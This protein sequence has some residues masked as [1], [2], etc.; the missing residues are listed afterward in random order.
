MLRILHFTSVIIC[1]IYSEYCTSVL[2]FYATSLLWVLLSSV[3]SIS[4]VYSQY[5]IHVLC[6]LYV[7]IGIHEMSLLITIHLFWIREIV[8]MRLKK[9]CTLIVHN[10]V[11]IFYGGYVILTVL[12]FTVFCLIFSRFLANPSLRL[13]VRSETKRALLLD[14]LL[15]LC[16]ITL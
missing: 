8:I 3:T 13:T 7:C 6:I 5:C 9:L 16:V 15:V 10:T 1:Y 14:I 11:F 12:E 4:I 2:H